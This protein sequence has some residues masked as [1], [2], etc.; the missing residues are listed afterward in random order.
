[1]IKIELNETIKNAKK[2]K[3]QT[4]QTTIINYN[5]TLTGYWVNSMLRRCIM[6]AIKTLTGI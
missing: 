2:D 6:L 3:K 4:L 1:M 5:F